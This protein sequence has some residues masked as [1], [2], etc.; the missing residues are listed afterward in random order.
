MRTNL[1]GVRARVDR[2]AA[3]IDTANRPIVV[4]LRCSVVASGRSLPRNVG[5]PPMNGRACQTRN[6]ARAR[7][8]SGPGSRR[9][10][11]RSRRGGGDQ[12]LATPWEPTF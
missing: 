3:I 4:L 9:T 1:H 6:G 7:G 11:R 8:H 2:L 5:A 10:Y 12:A